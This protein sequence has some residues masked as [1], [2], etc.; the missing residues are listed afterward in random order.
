MRRRTAIRLDSRTLDWVN[1]AAAV[2]AP[3][4][5]SAALIPLRAH[6][7]NTNI[8]LLMVV[9]E[10]VVAI[11]GRRVAA[12]VGG[13]S[14]AVW[15]DFFQVRPYYSFSIAGHNDLETTVLLLGVAVVVGELTA[16]GRFYRAQA[17]ETADELAQIHAV[18]EMVAAGEPLDELIRQVERILKH[19]LSLR[20]CWFETTFAERPGPFVARSGGIS[21]GS[22]TWAAES[23]GLPGKDVSLMVEGQGRP[24]GRFVLRPSVGT[25]ISIDKLTVA[26]ALAD[27]V[28]AAMAGQP[29]VG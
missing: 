11:P 19:T 1:L 29:T 8:A 5:V 15:F 25:P 14:A 12:A 18:A 27:Q 21:W 6:I 9:V 20:A 24:F 13:V 23:M 3:L 17:V 10:V 26:V 28:G 7:L 4:C 16:R 2:L 22:L